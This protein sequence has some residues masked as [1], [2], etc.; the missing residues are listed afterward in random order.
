MAC[1]MSLQDE[2]AVAERLAR[3]D[4]RIAAAEVAYRKS[5]DRSPDTQVRCQY[6][7]RPINGHGQCGGCG[8]YPNDVP[9]T[10]NK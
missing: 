3:Y 7:Y 6:C 2:I 8:R 1:K 4:T 9:V 5:V 10:S